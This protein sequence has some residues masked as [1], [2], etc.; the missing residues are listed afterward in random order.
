MMLLMQQ[1]LAGPV[2]LNAQ[3]TTS[4]TGTDFSS[5]V[6]S[7]M[8]Q[9]PQGLDAAAA[10]SAATAVYPAGLSDNDW[11][12]WVEGDAFTALAGMCVFGTVT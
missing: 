11:E 9:W 6:P 4:S 2:T 1:M 3:R 12:C 8:S 7:S 5:R 10:V